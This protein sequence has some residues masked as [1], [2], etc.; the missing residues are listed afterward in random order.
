MGQQSIPRSLRRTKD[1]WERLARTDPLWAILTD[2][3]KK[4]GGWDKDAFFQSG[5]ETV[6]DEISRLRTRCDDVGSAR[7]LDFGCGVGRLT[8]GLSR[9]FDQVIGVDISAGMIAP[10]N[11]SLE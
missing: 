9:H 2:P 3:D 6:D 11:V 10:M 5:V 7:A 4:N 1:H 8:Q